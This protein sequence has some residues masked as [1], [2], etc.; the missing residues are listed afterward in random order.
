ML[1]MARAFQTA[2]GF[3]KAW[4]KGACNTANPLFTAEVIHEGITC[5]GCGM[6]PLVGIRH[7]SLEWDNYDL[8]SA[9]HGQ[10]NREDVLGCPSDHRFQSV[11]DGNME[12]QD[13]GAFAFQ[14]MDGL[15]AMVQSCG[16]HVEQI[17]PKI[18]SACR[19]IAQDLD[20]KALSRVVEL[21]SPEET[22]GA[23]VHAFASKMKRVFDTV[24]VADCK[25]QKKFWKR[26]GAAVHGIFVE[27]GL[28]ASLTKPLLTL[29]K[30]LGKGYM[31]G[32]KASGKCETS[33]VGKCLRHVIKGFKKQARLTARGG[34]PPEQDSSSDE[35]PSSP[36]GSPETSASA[37]EASPN[38]RS[39][40]TTSSD[41]PY[42][43]AFA[44]LLMHPNEWFDLQPRL[45]CSRP[46][47]LD[48]TTVQM[49]R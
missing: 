17:L 49:P 10:A 21:M 11:P 46:S 2:K 45:P 32:C 28:D 7:K 22:S 34:S 1:D 20:A 36:A 35:A 19:S 13:T 39:S 6:S 30:G 42:E 31:K 14:N 18:A 33:G 4:S 29:G 41:S 3:G 25:I 12:Q 44:A 37:A 38:V 5:D 27:V 48:P 8:C 40:P 26:F 24:H 47:R 9:C 23:D 16:F 15:M 43:R